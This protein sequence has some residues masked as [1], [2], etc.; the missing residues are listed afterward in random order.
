MAEIRIRALRRIGEMTREIERLR[1]NQYTS[2]TGDVACSR[3]SIL[4]SAGISLRDAH[5]A[6][7]IAGMGGGASALSE[8]FVRSARPSGYVNDLAA[9]SRRTC[10]SSV[11][12]PSCF[13]INC[14]PTT[15]GI[16][17]R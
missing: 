13:T 16:P 4:R 9:R 2:A 10:F 12:T 1:E 5:R 8:T 11:S 14:P 7:Q 3:T 17:W 6:E 15:V